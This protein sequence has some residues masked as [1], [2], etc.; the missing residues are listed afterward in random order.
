M[1]RGR[2]MDYAPIHL[3]GSW[4]SL[5]KV[6]LS[7]HGTHKLLVRSAASLESNV[8]YSSTLYFEG[9]DVSSRYVL[10]GINRMLSRSNGPICSGMVGL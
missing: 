9:P 2:D 3:S 8:D 5:F 7:T 10:A 1:D 6:R 4:R